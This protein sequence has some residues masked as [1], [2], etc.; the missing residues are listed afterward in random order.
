M[1]SVWLILMMKPSGQEQ[2]ER[3]GLI[4]L[5]RHK[6]LEQFLEL[7]G[8]STKNIKSNI[9]G[10][11][12]AIIVLCKYGLR[13]YTHQEVASLQKGHEYHMETHQVKK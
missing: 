10:K 3:V 9:I 1:H 13:A 11:I 7:H 6:E 12:N 2:L 8:F 4:A 5:R